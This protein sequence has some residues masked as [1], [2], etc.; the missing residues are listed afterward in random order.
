[1]G[2]KRAFPIIREI[3]TQGFFGLDTFPVRGLGEQ[4]TGLIGAVNLDLDNLGIGYLWRTG[5][6]VFEVFWIRA[7]QPQISHE[8]SLKAAFRPHSAALL[9]AGLA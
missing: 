3:W 2:A 4:E 7:K 1:M 9:L 6:V 8:P 5:N